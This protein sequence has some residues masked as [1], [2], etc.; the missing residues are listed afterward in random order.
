MN[1]ALLYLFSASILAACSSTNQPQPP[2]TMKF[3][4]CSQAKILLKSNHKKIEQAFADNDANMIGN[5]ELQNRNIVRSNMQC[6]PKLE[7]IYSILE[8]T[9]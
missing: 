3:N 4:T 2:K 7:K 6:F 1:K 9:A 5:L 8:K